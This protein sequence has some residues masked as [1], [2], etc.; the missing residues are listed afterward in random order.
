MSNETLQAI[1]RNIQIGKDVVEFGNAIT[2]LRSN[3][4]FKAV[5]LTGYFEQEAIRL[6]HLKSDPGMQSA[7][8]QRAIHSQMESIGMLSQYFNTALHKAALAS[9]SVADDQEALEELAS[10]EMN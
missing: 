4:D 2:R 10:E 8:M 6:V 7:D 5:I 3:K 9:K 1:E